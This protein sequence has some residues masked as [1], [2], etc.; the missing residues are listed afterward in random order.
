MELVNN[1]IK[2]Y[3]PTADEQKAIKAEVGAAP[4][5]KVY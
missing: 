3:E 1:N 2:D 5:P 4:F